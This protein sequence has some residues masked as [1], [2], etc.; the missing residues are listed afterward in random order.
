MEKNKNKILVA[1][2]QAVRK[3]RLEIGLTQESFADKS[4][5]HRTYI[6]GVERGKR[7]VALLNLIQIAQALELTPEEFL[8]R[9]SE[10]LPDGFPKL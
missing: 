6:G 10:N 5:L 8:E 2:G 9:V 1:F 4:Q 3:R 7:N